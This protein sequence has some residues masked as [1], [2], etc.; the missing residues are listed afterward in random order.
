[1]KCFS[2]QIL[3]ALVFSVSLAKTE[4][5]KDGWSESYGIVSE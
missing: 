5:S 3:L 2:F 4:K 1:M